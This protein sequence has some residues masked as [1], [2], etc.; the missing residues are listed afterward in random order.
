[1]TARSQ[2]DLHARIFLR[3]LDTAGWPAIPER[4][5]AQ[6]RRDYRVLAAAASSW[7]PVARV[8]DAVARDA[9]HAVSVRV[10]WPTGG[11]RPRPLVVWFHG[12]NFV[13]GDLATA[14]GTCRA[15]A[16]QSGAVVVSL[17]PLARP[18]T[19]PS[20][21]PTAA[22]G[23]RTTGAPPSSRPSTPCPATPSVRSST[24][25]CGSRVQPD[26]QDRRGLE[27]PPVLGVA[28][29]V[30]LVVIQFMTMSHLPDV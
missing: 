30:P 10:Y 21:S 20:S 18:L 9:D 12:G 11:S 6:A 8:S 24:G 28:V 17:P 7:Q 5:P 25:N 16:N 19:R 13:V 1:M 4:T 3:G 23:W 2:L 26:R 14:D 22:T 29:S 27:E 15:L